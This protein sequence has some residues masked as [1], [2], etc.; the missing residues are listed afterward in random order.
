MRSAEALLCLRFQEHRV[1]G[2]DE[3][4]RKE[5]QRRASLLNNDLRAT[6]H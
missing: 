1:A 4:V 5:H 2:E 3:A 6:Q